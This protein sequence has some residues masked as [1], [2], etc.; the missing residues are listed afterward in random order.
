VGC[1]AG[2]EDSVGGSAVLPDTKLILGNGPRVVEVTCVTIGSVASD[3]SPRLTE[4]TRPHRPASWADHGILT[5]KDRR[6]PE[7]GGKRRI[8]LNVPAVVVVRTILAS[9]LQLIGVLY[10]L[11]V[12]FV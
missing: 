11:L 12:Q 2:G 3:F 6:L 5:H 4:G 1:A 9:R 10:H 8:L 7:R